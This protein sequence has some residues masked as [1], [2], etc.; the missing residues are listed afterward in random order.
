MFKGSLLLWLGGGAQSD[1]GSGIDCRHFFSSNPNA[2]RELDQWGLNFDHKLINLTG[3]V[4]PAEKICQGARS[5]PVPRA[6]PSLCLCKKKKK[7]NFTHKP[8]A[9]FFYKLQYDLNPRTADWARES[10]GVPLTSAPPLRNWLLFYS[11]RNE[12][13]AR[14]LFHTLEKVAG[15]LG[16]AVEKPRL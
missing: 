7:A 5:V 15:P 14:A 2:Q 8:A 12:N 3:R 1:S 16:I 4:L 9:L 11:R 6:S 10:R 13:E